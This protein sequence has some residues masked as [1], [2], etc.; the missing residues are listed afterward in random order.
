MAIDQ[1]FSEL[2]KEVD[3]AAIYPARGRT[4]FHPVLLM[5]ATLVQFLEGLTDRQFANALPVRLDW[6]Y[7]LHMDLGDVGFDASVMSDFR[8][9][10]TSNDATDLILE[11]VLKAAKDQGLLKHE[12]QRSDSTHILAAVRDLNRLE[13][14]HETVRTTME[15]LAECDFDF[16]NGIAR[17]DWGERYGAQCFN[18]R[19]PKSENKKAQ[20]LSAIAEDGRY[21]LEEIEKNAP[22]AL[23]NHSSVEILRTVLHQ[24]IIFENENRLRGRLRK[25][26][27]HIVAAADMLISPHDIEARLGS[28]REIKHKGYKAHLTE[29]LDDGAPH[30]ITNVETTVATTTD[31]EM[32]PHIEDALIKKN[33]AP[34]D[35]LVDSG[36]TDVETISRARE[37]GIEVIGPIRQ[38]THW[39]VKAGK[40]FDLSHFAIDW[41][42]ETAT[43]PAGKVSTGWS[44]RTAEKS[45]HVKF[46]KK[47][48][49][50]CP[51]RPDCTKGDGP[52][53]IQFKEK[54]LYE[55][56]DELRKREKT[57]PYKSLAVK[58][59]GIEGTISQI[60]RRTNM[61]KSRYIGLVKTRLQVAAS[62]AAINVLRL[63]N[64]ICEFPLAQTRITIIS[65]LSTSAKAS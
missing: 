36:Y 29:T 16:V 30:L 12:T 60:I 15:A 47:D 22:P 61:R 35:H 34:K 55:L 58:R 48:C 62:A 11:S 3:Y 52:R 33:L 24:Q 6:K 1:K 10:I 23:K 59:A 13:F 38:T 28:K 19:I 44:L 54:G 53:T 51:F 5:R 8:G 46:A 4:G 56:Q 20:W 37:N 17:K 40:G 7:F 65:Y 21:L 57:E 25:S 50:I 42:S 9:R 32:R 49:K 45:I 43:C 18:F 26:D 2:F 27:E 39:Q 31:I 14:V 63:W 64:Y 41:E